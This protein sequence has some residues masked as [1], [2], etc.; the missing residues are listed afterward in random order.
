MD[1]VSSGGTAWFPGGVQTAGRNKDPVG[2]RDLPD[3]FPRTHVRNFPRKPSTLLD[4]K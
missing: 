3:W 4:A 2:R 1:L